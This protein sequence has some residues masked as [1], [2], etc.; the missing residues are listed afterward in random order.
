MNK[1]ISVYPNPSSSQFT[2]SADGT[3]LNLTSVEMA[4]ITGRVI[5]KK[6]KLSGSS[7]TFSRG[8]LSNGI[9]VLRVTTDKGV[10]SKRVTL[11]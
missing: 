7:A 4:D 11:Q 3:T 5:W 6:E 10:V 1:V 2:V 9:Y 8:N